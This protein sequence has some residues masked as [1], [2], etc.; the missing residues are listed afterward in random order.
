MPSTFSPMS[1][2]RSDDK[3][4]MRRFRNGQDVRYLPLMVRNFPF[5]NLIACSENG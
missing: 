4:E 1:T 3:E 5:P 2:P